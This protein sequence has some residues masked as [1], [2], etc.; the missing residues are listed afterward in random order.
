MLEYQISTS[1]ATIISFDGRIIEI[2]WMTSRQGGRFHVFQIAKIWI[3][4]DKHGAHFLNFNS[5]YADQILVSGL[6]ISESALAQ[7]QELVLAVQGA[8]A[9][10][11]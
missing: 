6:A 4:T 1:P 7:T 5:K 3:E 11:A 2:F 9:G 8:M 10:Y